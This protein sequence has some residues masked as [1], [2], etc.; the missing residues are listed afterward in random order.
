MMTQDAVHVLNLVEVG[1]EGM[2]VAGV[3]LGL[4]CQDVGKML[5]SVCIQAFLRQRSC[6]THSLAQHCRPIL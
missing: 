5:V 1:V 4:L 6:Q 2:G 3:E